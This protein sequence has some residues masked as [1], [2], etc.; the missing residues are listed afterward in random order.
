MN[1]DELREALT[2]LQLQFDNEC[3]EHAR[4]IN[5]MERQRA[6]AE[7]AEKMHAQFQNAWNAIIEGLKQDLIRRDATIADLESKQTDR[8]WL[9][10]ATASVLVKARNEIE[11][12]AEHIKRMDATIE[13]Q[14]ALI[15]RRDATIERLSD[16]IDKLRAQVEL[17]SANSQKNDEAGTIAMM[18][19]DIARLNGIIQQDAIVM[20]RQNKPIAELNAECNAIARRL[21]DMTKREEN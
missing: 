14:V 15:K 3:R 5:E 19:M 12:S 11:Q 9:E 13:R 21:L 8:A 6:R 10:E 2:A 20:A 7:N 16:I 4:T 17:Q 18:H 1:V